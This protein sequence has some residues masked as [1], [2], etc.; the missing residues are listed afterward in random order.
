MP[1]I[2]ALITFDASGKKQLSESDSFKTSS[3]AGGSLSIMTEIDSYGSELH[4]NWKKDSE[5]SMASSFMSE[6]IIT[7]DSEVS[8]KSKKHKKNKKKT[9]LFGKSMEKKYQLSAAMNKVKKTLAKPSRAR[10]KS[11]A[12]QNLM[13]EP[14]SPMSMLAKALNHKMGSTAQ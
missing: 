4:K 11:G 3:L 8:K 12:V 7:T 13:Q 1:N 14:K 10:G 9:N 2:K 6:S 5:Q